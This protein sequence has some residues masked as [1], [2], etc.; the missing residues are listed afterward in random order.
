MKRVTENL[1]HS[2]QLRSMQSYADQTGLKSWYGHFKNRP[3]IV[4]VHGEPQ[5]QECLSDVLQKEL[6]AR[7]TIAQYRQKIKLISD[8]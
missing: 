6:N 7:V 4:L 1:L 8:T 3:R 2:I 5:A